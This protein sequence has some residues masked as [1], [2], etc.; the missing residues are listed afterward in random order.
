MYFEVVRWVYMARLSP[1]ELH[2][3]PPGERYDNGPSMTL[4]QLRLALS[5]ER[6]PSQRAIL[7]EKLL[8]LAVY[9]GGVSV[10]QVAQAI[11]AHTTGII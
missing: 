6:D 4:E 7:E 11:G 9:A 1:S 2:S 5:Q 10:R 3:R 8:D